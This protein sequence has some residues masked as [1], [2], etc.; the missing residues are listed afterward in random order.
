MTINKKR[1]DE[2]AARTDDQIDYSEI[3]LLDESF[4]KNA[5]KVLPDPTQA[6]TLRI[7]QSV[8]ESFKAQGKGYQ[9][10]MNA[11]LESY[12]RSLRQR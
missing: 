12:V 7:K 3:P 6:V 4:W 8:L 11:V 2:L 1:L 5:Q 9:T 10:R